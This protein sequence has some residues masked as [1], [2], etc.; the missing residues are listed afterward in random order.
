M[1]F[2]S[3]C[4]ELRGEIPLGTLKIKYSFAK[5]SVLMKC[6]SMSRRVGYATTF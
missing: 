5:T 1:A 3:C 2:E 6:E 4:R